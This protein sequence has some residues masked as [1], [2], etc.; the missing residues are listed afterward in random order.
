MNSTFDQDLR[1][2]QGEEDFVGFKPV[3]T[4]KRKPARLAPKKSENRDQQR[5]QAVSTHEEPVHASIGRAAAKS[6]QAN[7][8]PKTKVRASPPGSLDL[9]CPE[10]RLSS[11]K[12]IE[13][14]QPY[15]GVYKNAVEA[16]AGNSRKGLTRAPNRT[17]ILAPQAHSR[18]ASLSNS[19]AHNIHASRHDVENEDA[20]A[21]APLAGASGQTKLKD[22][23]TDVHVT[24]KLNDLQLQK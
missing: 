24:P 20:E 10:R 21:L 1:T 2:P 11:P 6:Q 5:P 23:K 7:A 4:A 18:R 22:P 15:A 3:L 19:V 13:S 16:P 9:R 17:K 8:V 14:Q 12:D